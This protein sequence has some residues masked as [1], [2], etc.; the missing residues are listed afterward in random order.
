MI[1]MDL[2][3]TERPTGIGK[4]SATA[5]TTPEPLSLSARHA[6]AHR[7]GEALVRG[8]RRDAAP[9]EEKGWLSAPGPGLY[10]HHSKTGAGR[11]DPGDL[12]AVPRRRAGFNE[13][14][15]PGTGPGLPVGSRTQD[16]RLG[17][18][19]MPLVCPDQNELVR[20]DSGVMP[21][22]F[23]TDTP[24]ADLARRTGRGGTGE[25]PATLT[26]DEPRRPPPARL[27]RSDPS[28]ERGRAS[29]R[30]GGA[31]RESARHPPARLS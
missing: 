21:M 27:A 10:P 31:H 28:G 18:A 24:A 23:L 8:C 11:P 3:R 1:A 9:S 19:P 20:P 13:I 26:S 6:V 30:R 17:V 29:R 22:S 2:A 14:L 25:G 7:K 12:T 4:G 15:P 16:R 5:R